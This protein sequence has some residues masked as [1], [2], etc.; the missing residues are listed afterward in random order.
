MRVGGTSLTHT[1]MNKH[2]HSFTSAPSVFVWRPGVFAWPILSH[3]SCRWKFTTTISLVLS[4]QLSVCVV[5]PNNPPTSLFPSRPIPLFFS[6]SLC[7]IF[8]FTWFF[9]ALPLHILL[10]PRLFSLPSPSSRSPCRSAGGQRD[11]LIALLVRA[12]RCLPSRTRLKFTDRERFLL[13][14]GVDS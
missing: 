4:G 9:T 14:P 6:L 13:R 7:V 3:P 2:T 5:S 1:H 11:R 8:S 12:W 10:R